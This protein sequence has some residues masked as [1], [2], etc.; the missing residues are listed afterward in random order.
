MKVSLDNYTNVNAKSSKCK[1]LFDMNCHHFIIHVWVKCLMI[2]KLC[3]ARLW[4]LVAQSQ[5]HT[6]GSRSSPLTSYL[7]HGWE[8][9][10]GW[11]RRWMWFNMNV[12]YNPNHLFESRSSELVAKIL[13]VSVKYVHINYNRSILVL[14]KNTFQSVLPLTLHP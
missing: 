5:N 6:D 1:I 8:S 11:K 4:S 7:F 10:Y 13:T 2:V 14:H 9:T 12:S 3:A